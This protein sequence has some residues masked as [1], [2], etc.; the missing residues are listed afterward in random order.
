[1]HGCMGWMDR[2]DA[3]MDGVDGWIGW[4]GVDEWMDRMDE[5]IKEGRGRN[6]G[7]VDRIGQDREGDY[8]FSG[9]EGRKGV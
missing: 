2:M 4:M 8:L 9:N 1:M 6:P 5:Y 7:R 3:C